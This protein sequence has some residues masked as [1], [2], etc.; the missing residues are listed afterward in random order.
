MHRKIIPHFKIHSIDLVQISFRCESVV[1]W[2]GLHLAKASDLSLEPGNPV[3]GNLKFVIISDHLQSRLNC[4]SL[5]RTARSLRA[6]R[7]KLPD[8]SAYNP[9]TFQ[10]L[11]PEIDARS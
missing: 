10:A 9:P 7:T 4:S 2:I 8:A 3:Q 1:C 11:P 5:S 6:S